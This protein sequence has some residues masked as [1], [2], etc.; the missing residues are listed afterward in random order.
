MQN[1]ILL[2]FILPILYRFS[3][4]F[5]TFQLKEYRFDRF[6]EYLQTPQWKKALFSIF[7]KFEIIFIFVLSFLYFFLQNLL[8]LQIFFLVYLLFLNIFYLYK[9]FKKSV[10]L[11]KITS[12]LKLLLIVIFIWFIL[13]LVWFYYFEISI[14]LLYIYLFLII[15][16]PYVIIFIWNF[17]TLPI[18]NFK[19][20]KLINKAI[21]KSKK[22][23]KPIKIAITWSYWKSSVKEYLWF[24]LEN[25]W[26]TLKTPKNINTELWVSNLIL[27]KLNNDYDYFV[28]EAWAY[29][30]GE[31]KTLWEIID[32]KYWFITAIWNQHIW[33]FWSQENII[34]W[35]TELSQK[36]LENNWILYVNWDNKFLKNFNYPK[37]LNVVKYWLWESNQAK[38]NILWFKDSFLEFE[39]NYKNKKQI[40]KTNLLWEHNIINLTWILAFLSDLK[41]D[42]KKIKN[43]LKKLPTPEHTLEIIK[44]DD[45]IFIDDTYNLSIDW[46]FAWINVLKYFDWEKVLVLDDILELWKDSKKIHFDIWKNIW[47]KKLVDK[48]L[49]IW[50]NYKKDFEKWL[51]SWWFKKENILSSFSNTNKKSI[52]LLEWRGARKINNLQKFLKNI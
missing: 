30:I 33:L 47:K 50:T 41:I 48:I 26:N 10:F 22:I 23:K 27:D 39:F 43:L 34:K 12:R 36:V 44:K 25:I 21:L 29:R 1:L 11:P 19:K 17:I 46:L 32:H 7:F 52:V 18:V 6:K 38:S 13:D 4:W 8:L 2:L 40:L 51:L 14:F 16:F 3:F 45:L 37:K 9:I 49:Y 24:I 5:Y 35:K 15:L 20:K 31:I 42:F 28:A